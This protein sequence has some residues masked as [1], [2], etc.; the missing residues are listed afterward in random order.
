MRAVFRFLRGLV[1]SKSVVTGN[2]LRWNNGV[3]E[4][5]GKEK[6][7]DVLGNHSIEPGN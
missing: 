1:C 5:V 4:M 6:F 7:F 3:R 2:Y